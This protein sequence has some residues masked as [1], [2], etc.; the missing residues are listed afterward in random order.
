MG[1]PV[2]SAG[3]ISKSFGTS[4]ELIINLYDS[5]PDSFNT[6]EPLLVSIDSLTVPLFL[7]KFERRGV[8]NALVRF[9][10]FDTAGRAAELIG[11]EFSLC[12]DSPEE[13]DDD[14]VYFEDLVGYK[15]FFAGSE[16][17]GVIAGFIDSEHNP[18]FTVALGDRKA[19]VPAS[20]DFIEAIDFDHKTITFALPEGLL[21]LYL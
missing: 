16:H 14:L 10:D 4:G 18:L 9:A 11:L 15:A 8:S 20:E 19:M 3:R 6:E 7:E 12:C 17:A 1:A 5:F 13:D 2:T 21:E